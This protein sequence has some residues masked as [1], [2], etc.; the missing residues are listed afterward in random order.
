MGMKSKLLWLCI[1]IL[2][3]IITGNHVTSAHETVPKLS[4]SALPDLDLAYIARLPRYD[5]DASKNQPEVG[6]TVIFEA[7]IANR[8]GLATGE[9]T[10]NWYIDGLLV[11]NGSHMSLLPGDEISLSFHWIWQTGLHTVGL[12]LDPTNLVSEVSEINNSIEDQTNALA[13]GF[14]VEQSVYDYFN[15]H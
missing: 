14:W 6:D 2:S 9:F 13:V 4:V 3:L 12:T 11:N 1:I 5:Y 7:H 10:Y 15:Q 8:G